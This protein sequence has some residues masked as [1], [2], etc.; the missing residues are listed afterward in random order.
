M[1]QNNKTQDEIKSD[2]LEQVEKVIKVSEKYLRNNKTQDRDREAFA[3]L[4]SKQQNARKL[5]TQKPSFSD[6]G[7][8]KQI[9]NSC[10]EAAFQIYLSSRQESSDKIA[11]LERKLEF[12]HSDLLFMNKK[13][14]QL[15]EEL[16][17]ERD[18]VDSMKE[19]LIV[20]NDIGNVSLNHVLK[21][22]RE[23]Q[24]KRKEGL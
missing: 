14:D 5:H 9:I 8:R 23:R 3:T 10:R 2:V 11:E 1:N 21:K 18:C 12:K 13:Y 24:E 20:P 15:R 4:W 16:R 22:A 6:A 7:E 19:S 17:L